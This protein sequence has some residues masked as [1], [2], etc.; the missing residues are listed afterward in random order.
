[1]TESIL[2]VS[3]MKLNTHEEKIGRRENMVWDPLQKVLSPLVERMS[4]KG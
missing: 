4:E 3:N 2:K 1:M